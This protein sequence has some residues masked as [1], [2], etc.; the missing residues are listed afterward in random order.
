MKYLATVP[1]GRAAHA[2]HLIFGNKVVKVFNG[3]P[4]VKEFRHDA[5]C[6]RGSEKGIIR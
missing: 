5:S 4:F 2:L 3:P 1:V 6:A